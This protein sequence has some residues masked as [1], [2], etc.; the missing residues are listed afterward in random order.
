MFRFIPP[1]TRLPSSQR[2]AA[3]MLRTHRKQYVF[4]RWVQAFTCVGLVAMEK[5]WQIGEW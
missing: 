4:P 2:L 3:D 1:G 5:G